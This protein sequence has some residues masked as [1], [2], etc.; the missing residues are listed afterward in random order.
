VQLEGRVL[1]GLL[2]DHAEDRRLGDEAADEA[3]RRGGEP[4]PPPA[5][6]V[7][8]DRVDD[9]PGELAEP[10]QEPHLVEGI[11]A[12]GLQP[13]TAEGALQVGVPLQQRDL[14]PTAGKQVGEGR[15]G[16]PRP[17]DD[18]VSDRHDATPIGLGTITVP[19][20]LPNARLSCRGRPQGR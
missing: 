6:L 7:E 5:A 1:A 10:V 18:D 15:S 2:G 13:I 20:L 17:D 8:V 11:Q 9:G 19:A 3:Q 14:H 12:A 4:G 16:G